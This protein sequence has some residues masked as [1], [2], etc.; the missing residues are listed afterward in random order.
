MIVTI[1]GVLMDV[2]ESKDKKTGAK[3][4]TAIVYQRG[5]R[6]LVRYRFPANQENIPAIGSEF[7]GTGFLVAWSGRGGSI[8]FMVLG[9]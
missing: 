6:D 3:K 2:I 9:D 8:E 5:Q 7:S 1:N 4:L